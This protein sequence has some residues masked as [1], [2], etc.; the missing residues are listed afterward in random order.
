EG[1]VALAEEHLRGNA[2]AKS[3]VEVTVHMD[4]DTLAGHADDDTALSAETCRRLCCDAGLVPVLEDA[5]GTTLDVGRRTRSIPAAI[6]R[7]LAIRDGGCRFPGCTHTRFVDGHH[8]EHWLSGGE[9]A[10]S[11]LVSLCHYHH[12]HVHELGFDVRAEDG[13][14]FAFFTPDGQRIE[15]T[16]DRGRPAVTLG[17]STGHKVPKPGWDGTPPDYHA[18]VDMLWRADNPP[19]HRA[20]AK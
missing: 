19:P 2:E 14:E 3:P 11:N 17:N 20:H 4:A 9:T 10:L 8:V 5:D 7:A 16:G 1:A 15:P 18:I 13:G 6:R 12:K